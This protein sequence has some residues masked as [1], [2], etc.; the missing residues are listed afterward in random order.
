MQAQTTI[1]PTGRRRT[2]LAGLW[3]VIRG[4]KY[5]ADAYPPAKP[6]RSGPAASHSKER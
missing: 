3:S 1:E 4:D 6:G 5:M 2:M